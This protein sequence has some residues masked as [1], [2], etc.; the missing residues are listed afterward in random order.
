MFRLF[1]SSFA[2]ILIGTFTL[3]WHSAKP[4]VRKKITVYTFILTLVLL[5]HRWYQFFT[6]TAD[7]NYDFYIAFPM[8][9]V[10]RKLYHALLVISTGFLTVFAIGLWKYK[11]Y[12]YSLYGY[13]LLLVF[14]SVLLLSIILYINFR[15]Y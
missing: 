14:T 9:N 8:G 11:K 1:A 15:P 7:A 6:P 5:L 10:T 12:A 3:I 13:V 4:K 2:A